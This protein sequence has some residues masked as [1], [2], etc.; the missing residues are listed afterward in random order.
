MKVVFL[1]EVKGVGKR[2]EEKEVA[3][4]YYRNFLAARRLA[5]LPNDPAAAK[6]RAEL[7][8]KV[9]QEQKTV[10][11][12]KQLAASF[13]NRE[14]TITAKA[15]NGKLFGSVGAAEIAKVLGV[16]PTM[17]KTEPIKTTG[18]HTVTL[19]FPHHVASTITVAVEAA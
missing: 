17:I 2:G 12:I 4:G 8:T 7:A 15:H 18:R 13:Q 5:V 10:A 19:T 6:L 9:T 1:A 16:E 11:Q 14:V 3:E